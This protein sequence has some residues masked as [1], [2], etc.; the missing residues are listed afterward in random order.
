MR[1]VLTG[2]AGFIGSHL[3]RALLDEGADVLVVDDLSTGRTENVDGRAGFVEADVVGHGFLD[4]GMAFR[5]DA[6]VHLAAQTSVAASVADPESDRRVNVDGTRNACVLARDAGS[7]RFLFAS[8]AAVYG[9]PVEV[10]LTEEAPLSPENPYGSSKL[11]AERVIASMLGPTGTVGVCLRLANVYGP[12]QD[13]RGEG[14]VVAVFV[15]RAARGEAL[16]VHGDGT[17]TRDFVYVEDVAAAFLS[18][19]SATM[20]S[21]SGG[22]PRVVNVSTG[23]ETS[24]LDLASGVADAVGSDLELA[25]EAPRPGDVPRSALDPG[26]AREIL[27]WRAE[28][29]LSEGISRTVAWS[30][31][32]P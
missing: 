32:T 14:G 9:D 31:G 24:V 27:G 19:L 20:P 13:A 16:R 1:V 15:D 18:A 29:A 10:P 11:E 23:T 7:D 26:K 3:C 5:P 2:G 25:F 21:L 8:T 17:Q 12:G 6:V 30:R 22:G 4:A 28:V